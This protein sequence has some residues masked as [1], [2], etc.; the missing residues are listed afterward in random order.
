MSEGVIHQCNRMPKYN[1]IHLL[2]IYLPATHNPI[3]VMLNASLVGSL[4]MTVEVSNS[5]SVA[6]THLIIYIMLQRS[7][8][9]GKVKLSLCLTN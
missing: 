2:Y 3:M 7:N 5:I 9:L 4:P 6:V 8:L 1:I